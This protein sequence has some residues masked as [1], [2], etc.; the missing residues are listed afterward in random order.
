MK[1]T[2]WI[3]LVSSIALMAACTSRSKQTP[4]NA[5][6][7]E[8][9]SVCTIQNATFTVDAEDLQG[10]LTD[11]GLNVTKFSMIGSG[12]SNSCTPAYSGSVH[13]LSITLNAPDEKETTLGNQLTMLT[14]TVRD[15]LQVKPQWTFHI[16]INTTFISIW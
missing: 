1:H 6:S 8:P 9:T 14:V 4:L 15:W 2:R 13:F 16:W 3:L 11:A 7:L 5:P 10:M 12:E